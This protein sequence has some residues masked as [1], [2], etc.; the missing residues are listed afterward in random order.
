MSG[1]TGR[2]AKLIFVEGQLCARH[3]SGSFYAE[4]DIKKE[5]GKA[6]SK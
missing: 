2:E 6:F 1:D 5:E 4:L 3:G